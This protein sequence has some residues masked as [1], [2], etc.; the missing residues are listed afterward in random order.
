MKIN[1]FWIGRSLVFNLLKKLIR[2]KFPRV[3]SITIADTRLESSDVLILDA[4][5]EAEYAV[6]HL[7]G[8]RHI[9]PNH[10]ILGEVEKDTP[11]VVYCSVG[12]RSAN[13]AQQLE[14][15]GFQSVFNLEGGLFEWANQGRSMVQNG[16]PTDR[17]HPYNEAWGRLLKRDRL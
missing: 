12:Y 7:A 2:L 10:P 11:I 14:Q 1:V 16:Q 8:A 17:V 9:D 5:S 6:S 3:Q 4:R 13:V 15:A